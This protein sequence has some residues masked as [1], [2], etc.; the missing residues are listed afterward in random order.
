MTI[1]DWI[2]L[3]LLDAQFITNNLFQI[4]D[5]G[6]FYVLEDSNR[7]FGDSF[8]L[9]V[10]PREF[11]E[12]HAAEANFYVY[13]FGG[14]YYYTP[15]DNIHEPQLIPLRYLGSAKQ[16]LNSTTHLG[17]H[18]LYELLNGSRDYRDWCKKAR[19]LGYS[20]LAICERNTLA[21]TMS[22][23]LECNSSKIKPI[24]GETVSVDFHDNKKIQDIHI[25]A[26]NKKG[27]KNVLNINKVI[28]IDSVNKC[29]DIDTLLTKG[30]GVAV[31]IH[32]ECPLTDKLISQLKD[33]F[34]FVFCQFN[35]VEYTSPQKDVNCLNAHRDYLD[36]WIGKI[37]PILLSDAYYLDQIDSV[38]K[39]LLNK[40]G[41]G[42]S[43]GSNEEYFKSVD[44]LFQDIANLFHE[45][46]ERVFEV[47]QQALQNL[48]ILGESCSF[49]IPLGKLHLPQY[50]M[51]PDEA[52]ICATNEDLFW[53]IIEQEIAHIKPAAGFTLDDY[54]DRIEIEADVI[55]RGGFQSYFLILWDIN[56][57]CRKSGILTGVGRGSAGGSLI[58]YMMG[59]TKLDPLQYGLL[60]E[61]FLNESRIQSSL[62]D[63]DTDFEGIRRE[64]VKQYMIDKYGKDYVCSVG[65]YTTLQLKG[66]IKDISRQH[67]IDFATSNYITAVLDIDKED[68]KTLFIN[69]TTKPKVKEFLCDN[70]DMIN[71]IPLCLGQPKSASIHACATVIV[72][73]FDEDG[74]P[75]TIYD[76]LPVRKTADGQLISEWE[77]SYTEKAGFLKED[78]LGIKQ[79]DKFRS[80][81]DLIK[82]TT[83]KELQLEDI[84]LNEPGVF[85][86]FQ[87]GLSE[88]VFHFGTEGLIGYS[89]SV[90]PDSIDDLIAMIALHRPGTMSSGAHNM[91]VKCKMGQEDPHYD[92]GLREVTQDTYGLYIYQEQ[93]MKAMQ[94]L[95]GFS[96]VEA[97]GVRKAMG[98]KIKEQM[99]GYKI[100]FL[101]GAAEKGCDQVEAEQ[102]WE[103]LEVF[104]GYG[105]NKSHAAAYSITG[106]MCNWL[107][108]TYPI[109]FWTVAFQFAKEADI[110][111]Y[112]SEIGRSDSGVVIRPPDINSSQIN[113]TAD[114]DKKYLYW[115]L[116]R[117]KQCG[118]VASAVIIEERD[119]GGKFFDI[120]EAFERLPKGKVKKDVFVNLILAGSFDSLYRIEEKLADR[121]QILREYFKLRKEEL[122]AKFLDK[123]EWWWRLQ[124]KLIS[125]LGSF[126]YRN[127]I[128]MSK[129]KEHFAKFAD[130][131]TLRDVKERERS[132]RIVAGIVVEVKERQSK[133]GK[134][135]NIIIDC[136]SDL[137][138]VTFWAGE[139]VKA[140][141][142][143]IDSK[144]CILIVEGKVQF[145][146]FKYKANIINTDKDTVFEVL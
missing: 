140:R 101:K 49:E 133:N 99:D 59:I 109:Q 23:Q 4:P 105:F 38:I 53:H 136:N 40:I 43:S 116:G 138:A 17:V 18:G 54:M 82:E 6:R 124:Q 123:K 94:V 83:G 3:H 71:L 2:T 9:I 90:K 86:L 73:K 106:Y 142:E 51:N 127:V 112:I 10:D 97:D 122:P 100:L 42:G 120:E 104:S 50:E 89:K 22:F 78:I 11:T 85:E 44:Q 48:E 52:A 129:C 14:N 13:I 110:S 74:E 47:F 7:I 121:I 34:D 84:P 69:A 37:E 56:N 93:V 68:F 76:W 15:I 75:M 27:W 96:L 30:E 118:T 61:R 131:A 126:D 45:E 72:P 33:S 41:N 145:D 144:N 35:P 119:R 130:A 28:N 19:F 64:E 5:V 132:R 87:Q 12:A 55:S 62:P 46:D 70:A 31:V 60:F 146:D 107:K 91:Y 95:G 32:P 26:V 141:K 65:T 98:K 29:I 81:F 88:D 66:A 108:F 58:A 134:F 57:W 128:K 139:W 25:F 63:I 137:I 39:P 114:F 135:A 143:I 117:I 113:L 80:I 8:N 36:K 102:I 1:K 115:S 125:G 21:G 79:L 103:T 92:Y 24:L 67:E 20:S 111:R 77:G 16:Q